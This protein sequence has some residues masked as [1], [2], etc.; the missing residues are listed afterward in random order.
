[1]AEELSKLGVKTEELP[2][3][4]VVNGGADLHGAD[5]KGHHDHRIV[6]ALSLAGMALNETCCIDTAE[7]I[8]VTFP[9][10]VNLMK[11]IGAIM[12]LGK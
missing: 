4:L 6:M 8:N 1:M 11:N 10:Y 5:L 9:E 2:D 12:N 7:A 3:G